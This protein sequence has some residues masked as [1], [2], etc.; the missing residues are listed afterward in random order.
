[1]TRTC[2]AL[3]AGI[4]CVITA[5]C[6]FPAVSVGQTNNAPV[7]VSKLPDTTIAQDQS[8]TFACLAKD[9]DKD[10]VSFSL[11]NPPTGATITN[12]GIFTWKPTPS[13]GGRFQ[14][15][16]VITDGVLKTV[17]R[18][19]VTVTGAN[20]RPPF[21]IRLP[22]TTVYQAQELGFRYHATDPKNDTLV[23]RLLD[24]PPGAAITSSGYFSWKPG[25]SQKGEF[26]IVAL[27][28]KT[29]Y[30][31]TARSTV[32]VSTDTVSPARIKD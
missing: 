24:P 30:S 26:A 6:G 14:I 27:V 10:V 28:A 19:I 11:D 29:D 9:I 32:T 1:M 23:F 4:L 16:V 12:L 18:A 2:S 15:A 31:D 17:D 20:V 3:L 25:Y 7:F 21:V 8:L 5:S 13:Q 22:D